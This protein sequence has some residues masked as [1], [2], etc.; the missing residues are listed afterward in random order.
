MIRLSKLTDYASVVLTELARYPSELQSTQ[1]LAESTRIPRPT[2]TKV[3]KTLTRA[4]LTRSIQGP[5]GGYTLARD[6]RQIDLA[7]IIAAI[8]GPS[9]VTECATD[10]DECD[11][12]AHCHVMDHWRTVSVQINQLLRSVTLAELATPKLQRIPTLQVQD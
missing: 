2:V 5:R 12:T 1:H 11:L 7:D 4:G 9:G 8:E 6:A 3:L 10:H